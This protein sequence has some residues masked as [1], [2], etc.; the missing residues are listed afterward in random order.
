M[1]DNVVVRPR[2][3]VIA[4]RLGRSVVLVDLESNRIYEL[5]PTGARIWELL[6]E[7]CD[8]AAIARTLEQEFETAEID[9]MGE[10]DRVVAHVRAEGLVEVGATS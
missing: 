1:P 5:N 4:R 2:S 10:I 9:V 3:D 8:R 7:G 6:T